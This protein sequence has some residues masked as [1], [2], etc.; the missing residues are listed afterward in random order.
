MKGLGTSGE[1][2]V[3]TALRPTF[4]PSNLV[5]AYRQFEALSSI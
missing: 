5:I 2:G 1:P 4:I 3:H